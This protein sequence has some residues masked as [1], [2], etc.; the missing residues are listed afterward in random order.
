MRGGRRHRRPRI[1]RPAAVDPPRPGAPHRLRRGGRRPR[2]PQAQRLRPRRDAG[3]R[4]RR[5]APAYELGRPRRP[6]EAGR[7]RSTGRLRL[8][9]RGAVGP[10]CSAGGR[11]SARRDE[12]ETTYVL[13]VAGALDLGRRPRLRLARRRR[14]VTLVGDNDFG[15]LGAGTP[16]STRPLAS[17]GRSTRLTDVRVTGSR[18]RT[19]SARIR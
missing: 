5:S 2:R 12:D 7:A 1:G 19:R 6:G 11:S 9:A 15:P 17:P 14:L 4:R 16:R 18:L 13:L 10:P 8:A 3:P